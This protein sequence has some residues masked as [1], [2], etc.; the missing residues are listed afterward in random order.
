MTK[1]SKNFFFFL[2]DKTAVM[3]GFS[4]N[5]KK[6]YLNGEILCSYSYDRNKEKYIC[7]HEHVTYQ[8]GYKFLYGNS[9]SD[10]CDQITKRVTSYLRSL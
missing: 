4:T 1:I 5:E 6:I 7:R 10:L 3:C 8:K 9:P 2:C